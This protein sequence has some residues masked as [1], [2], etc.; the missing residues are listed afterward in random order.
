MKTD[1]MQTRMKMD[2]K[3]KRAAGTAIRNVKWSS[4][5][6]RERVDSVGVSNDCSIDRV[7]MQLQVKVIFSTPVNIIQ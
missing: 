6:C 7:D 2:R 4:V 5:F 3:R 1:S